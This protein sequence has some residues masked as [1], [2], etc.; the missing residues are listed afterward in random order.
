MKNNKIIKNIYKNVHTSKKLDKK[1]FDNTIYKKE[2]HSNLNKILITT[3][4][5]VIISTISIGVVF[6]DEI[7]ETIKNYF[8]TTRTTVVKIDDSKQEKTT[9]PQLVVKDL[10]EVN[11]DADL[12]EIRHTTDNEQTI[13]KKELEE[14]LGIN[15]LTSDKLKNDKVTI[16]RIEKENGKISKGIFW[17]RDAFE[18]EKVN[19]KKSSIT[20]GFRFLTKYSGRSSYTILLGLTKDDINRNVTTKYIDNL[21]TDAYFFV[22]KK[23]FND[24]TISNQ[25][26]VA[27]V[28]DNV[29]YELSATNMSVNMMIDFINTLK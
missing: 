23:D 6:A 29:G 10:K 18:L 19:N 14:K 13:S 4:I 27:F 11:Y 2:R 25:I 22:S 17:I 28:Y 5:I 24:D 15:F 16:Y 1:I 7:K 21:D 3:S 12:D 9:T 20:F 8:F 26:F